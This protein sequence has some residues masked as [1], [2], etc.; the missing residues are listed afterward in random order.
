VLGLLLQSVYRLF[1]ANAGGGVDGFTIKETLH[2]MLGSSRLSHELSQSKTS[3][4][5]DG[6]GIPGASFSSS[7]RVIFDRSAILQHADIFTFLRSSLNF[8]PDKNERRHCLNGPP[9]Q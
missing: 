6:R 3:S 8:F 5:G 7:M 2:G 4:S 9:Q 1:Q